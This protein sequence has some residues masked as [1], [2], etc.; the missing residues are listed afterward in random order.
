MYD[1]L[2]SPGVVQRIL[3]NMSFESAHIVRCSFAA[4]KTFWNL[5]FGLFGQ[6]YRQDLFD[7]V[8]C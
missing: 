3:T 6:Q 5:V 4:E 7:F 8:L 2:S 1:V